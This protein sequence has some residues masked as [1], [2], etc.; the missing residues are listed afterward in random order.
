LNVLKKIVSFQ[1]YHIS[2][3]YERDKR[4]PKHKNYNFTN[5]IRLAQFFLEFV[6]YVEIRIEGHG[7]I[8]MYIDWQW[9]EGYKC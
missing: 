3:G 2:K 7:I 8:R 9:S 1:L 4:N 5:S 6:F